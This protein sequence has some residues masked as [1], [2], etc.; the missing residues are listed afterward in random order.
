MRELEKGMFA[1]SLAGH[2]KGRLYIVLEA[3]G[4][5]VLLT[6][7]RYRPV[8]NPKR[9]NRSHIQPDYEDSGVFAPGM[10]ECAAEKNS[11]VRKAIRAK[12]DKACQKQM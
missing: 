11:A 6:D 9:K 12:E 7:G 1:R 3:D 8:E 10:T 2:D 4:K 5:S